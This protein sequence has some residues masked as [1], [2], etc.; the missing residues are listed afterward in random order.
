MNTWFTVF[1]TFF[2]DFAVAFALGLLYWIACAL[3][4]I[5]HKLAKL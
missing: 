3:E 1:Q 4:K 2:V 5:M